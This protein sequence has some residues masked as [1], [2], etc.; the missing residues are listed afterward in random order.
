MCTCIERGEG[1]PW[2]HW[3]LKGRRDS[4]DHS[5]QNIYLLFV[6]YQSSL[7]LIE[8]KIEEIQGSL[9]DDDDV[10]LNKLKTRVLKNLYLCFRRNQPE[11][12]KYKKLS[13]IIRNKWP[14]KYNEAKSK[15]LK[16]KKI[17]N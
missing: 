17:D 2:E 3:S 14:I 1:V 9:C 15:Y 4:H 11:R 10:Y 7:V 16:V 8:R 12:Y 13:I 6:T 5:P